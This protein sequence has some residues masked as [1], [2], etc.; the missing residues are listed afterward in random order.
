MYEYGILEEGCVIGDI[1]LLM[2]EA[3]SFSYF[4]NQKQLKPLIMLQI[5]SIE[6]MNICDRYKFSKEQMKRRALKRSQ[7]FESYKMTIL[8]KYMKCLK[9]NHSKLL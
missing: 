7:I 5:P 8:L 2:N 4:Y 6:F 3:N 9:K 1:S